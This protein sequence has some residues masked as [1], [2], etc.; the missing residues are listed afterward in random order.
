[1]N[2]NLV[3]LTGSLN[4]LSGNVIGIGSQVTTLSG[5]VA[6]KINLT[7]LSANGPLTYNNT[8][9]L[10][11]INI[12]NTTTTGALSVSD[13]NTFNNKVGFIGTAN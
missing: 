7:N 11:G 6:T 8:T 4:T 2:S 12:A 3:S 13:Y 5:I 1:M 9:G 10:F